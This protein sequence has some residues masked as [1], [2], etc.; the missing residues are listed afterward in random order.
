MQKELA[1]AQ[2]VELQAVAVVLQLSGNNAFTL[3][4]DSLYIFKVLQILE[5]VLCTEASNKK[6][7]ILFQ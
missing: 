1:L 6:V 7:K 5:T 2:I 3:Y 4:I